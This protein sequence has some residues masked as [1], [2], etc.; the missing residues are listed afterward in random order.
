MTTDAQCKQE[1]TRSQETADDI[2]KSLSRRALEYSRFGHESACQDW[3]D[4][5]TKLRGLAG[6]SGIF[7]GGIAA[8]AGN[9]RIG[10]LARSPLIAVVVVLAILALALGIVF[11]LRGL[12]V[13]NL[14]VPRPAR[15]WTAKATMQYAVSEESIRTVNATKA[16][17]DAR[18]ESCLLIGACLGAIVLIVVAG[19]P[20]WAE[21]HVSSPGACRTRNLRFPCTDCGSPESSAGWRDLSRAW[22]SAE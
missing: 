1:T 14:E 3:R 8:L 11:A 15:E 13:R 2:R 17:Q 22:A 21:H 5:E 4:L 20:L 19:G 18:A 10:E 12:R 9:N 16:E 6:I 7:I